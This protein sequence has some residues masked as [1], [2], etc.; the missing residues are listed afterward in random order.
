MHKKLETTP[1]NS[2][3]FFRMV[4][5]LKEQAKNQNISLPFKKLQYA[6]E[7]DY[8][9]QQLYHLSYNPSI[10]LLRYLFNIGI[11]FLN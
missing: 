4:Q 3:E 2:I 9:R 6:I 1:Q 11:S 5:V 8:L 7:S 10:I